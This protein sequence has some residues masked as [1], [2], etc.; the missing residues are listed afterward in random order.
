MVSRNR[1]AVLAV[2]AAVIAAGGGYALFRAPA[3]ANAAQA[4]TAPAAPQV[5]VAEVVNKSIVDWQ[6][7]SGRLEAIDRVDIRPLVSGTLTAVHFRDGTI[8]KKGDVLFTIDPRPYAAEVDR[9]AA[10][11]TARAPAS[12]T[13]S[14]LARGQRLLGDNAIAR[15]DFEEKQNAA[16]EAAAN[17]QGAQAALDYARLNLGYTRIEARWPAA[18]RAP[19]SR[20]ATWSPPAPPRCR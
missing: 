11:L 8:V 17:L 10:A 19:R 2:F 5:D 9:A 6:R 20:W 3:G 1:F 12:Y 15:R 16:R 14:E 7:Y 13:A 4:Q 18:S